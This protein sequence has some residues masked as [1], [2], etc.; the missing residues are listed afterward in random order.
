MKRKIVVNDSERGLSFFSIL[1]KMKPNASAFDI[2]VS[3]IQISGWVLIEEILSNVKPERIRLLITDQFGFTHPEALRRAYEY[4][5]KVKIYK[6]ERIY[7]PKVYLTYGE[8]EQPKGALVGSANISESGLMAGVEAGVFFSESPLLKTLRR[9]FNALFN[10]TERTI[11]LDK[12]LLI[13]I[14]REWR[15]AATDRLKSLKA[16][17]RKTL[18]GESGPRISPEDLLV[19]E[20]LFSTIRL[21]IGILSI[22]HA[23]NNIRNLRRL[24][25]VLDRYPQVSSKERSELRLLGFVNGSELTHLGRVAKIRRTEK[26]LAKT[27]CKWVLEQKTS[28]LE[29]INPRIASFKRAAQQ[30][31]KLD[32]G[33]RR[34]FLN[35]LESRENR[36]ILQTIELLC[37][38]GEVV[39]ELTL[40]DF[41]ILT[42]LLSKQDL[43]PDFLNKAIIDYQKNKGSR[44]W[45]G[46]DRK[47]IL[48]AWRDLCLE[49]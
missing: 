9:W 43:L 23:R 41:K 14:G 21:P 33:V 36:N 10:D 46:E 13:K 44:S 15:A 38:S 47:T 22:D 1:E 4:G 42:S 49:E 2:A 24:L 20:D 6:G 17:R 48:T 26:S 32:L 35:N 30:F 45:K 37:N 12:H 3:Y 8:D 16:Q 7:H 28:E 18:R 40:N 25:D 11:S 39:R 27:W 29:T 5:I 31:W 34:F 19:M